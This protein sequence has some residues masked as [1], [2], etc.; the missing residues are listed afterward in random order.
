MSISFKGFNEQVLTFRTEAELTPG[1]PVK[2]SESATV[3]PCADGDKFI[4][5]TVSCRDGIAA[6][7]VSGHVTLPYSGTAPELGITAVSAAGESDIKADTDGRA[8]TVVELDEENSTAG[9][10]L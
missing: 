4:G 10:L 3:A 7:Q 1:T 9:I 8:V 5:I 6:V 2:M